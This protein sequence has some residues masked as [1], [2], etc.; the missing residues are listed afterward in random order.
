MKPSKVQIELLQ[1]MAEGVTLSLHRGREPFCSESN[2]NGLRIVRLPTV[3]A[4]QREGWV[5]VA[6][7]TWRGC[8][9]LI[10]EKGKELIADD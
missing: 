3:W 7:D 5:R 2:G 10:T 8:D 6:N 9:F 4:M 1:R